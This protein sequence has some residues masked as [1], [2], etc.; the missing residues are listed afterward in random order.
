MEGLF[1]VYSS[2]GL[3]VREWIPNGLRCVL[4]LWKGGHVA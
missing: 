2:A 4:Y 3:L 1:T